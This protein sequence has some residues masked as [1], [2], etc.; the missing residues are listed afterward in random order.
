MNKLWNGWCV[1]NN[2]SFEMTLNTRNKNKLEELEL[3]RENLKY[4]LKIQEDW[5]AKTKMLLK[6][7]DEQIKIEQSK[8]EDE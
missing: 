1:V 3:N 4:R 7:I 6:D 2:K 5:V 8:K